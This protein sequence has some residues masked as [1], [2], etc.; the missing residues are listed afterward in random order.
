MGDIVEKTHWRSLQR[1][2]LVGRGVI[3]LQHD[4]PILQLNDWMI[5]FMPLHDIITVIDTPIH[6]SSYIRSTTRA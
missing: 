2:Q 3:N 4:A 6:Y 5:F 1:T